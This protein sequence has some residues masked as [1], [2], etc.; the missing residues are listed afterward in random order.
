[1]F[2]DDAIFAVNLWKPGIL[3]SFLWGCGCF[4]FTKRSLSARHLN[5]VSG[6][7]GNVVQSVSD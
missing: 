4:A 6:G 2:V 5:D 7:L 3:V 1:M